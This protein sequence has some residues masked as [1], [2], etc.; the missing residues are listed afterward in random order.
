MLE[1]LY[2][3]WKN[4]NTE[5]Q[6]IIAI[7]QRKNGTYEFKYLNDVNKAINKGFTPLI[8]FSDINR[9]YISDKLFLTFSSRLP[10]KRRKDIDKILK[11]YS[12]SQ[13]DEYELLKRSRGKL[14]IDNL[15]FISKEE[16]L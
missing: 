6:F 9:T 11:R 5:E 14:P 1:Q 15:E 7:L 13:Y 2:L 8:A 10:D 4:P 12:M 16:C 3:N